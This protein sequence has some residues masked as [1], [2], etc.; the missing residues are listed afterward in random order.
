MNMKII[1]IF[2]I[3][4]TLIVGGTSCSHFD[5]L[6]SNPD[7]AIQAPAAMMATTLILDVAKQGGAKYFIYDNLISKQIAWGEGADSYQYNDFGRTDFEGYTVL[8]VSSKMIEA[9]GEDDKN[10][11]TA[12]AK[13]IKAYKIF[14]ISM[15]VGDVP[16]SDAL[17]GEEGV[18]NPKYDTQKD[19]MVQVLADLDESYRLFGIGRDFDG[20]P[21]YGGDVELWKKCVRAFQLKVL[22]HLSKKESDAELS[23]KARFAQIVNEGSLFTSNAENFQ[24]VYSDKSGQLY[25]FCKLASNHVGLLI[26]SSVIIDNLKASNDYRLFYYASPAKSQIESGITSENWDAYLSVDPSETYIVNGRLFTENK[27]CGINDR[28]AGRSEGEPLIRL[29]FGEQNF[30]LAEAVIRGW[31]S[32][33]AADYYKKGIKASMDFIVK[34]TPNDQ[35]YHNGK[36]MTDDYITNYYTSQANIQLGAD[37]EGNLEKIILQRYLSSFMQHPYD[38]YYDYRRTGYPV[39]PISAATNLN[40]VKDKIPVRWMYPEDEFGF[41]AENANE[42]VQRQYE[43]SDEVNKLMWVLK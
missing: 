39:L 26:I 10:S 18:Q 20:D 22:L 1:N 5:D 7:S 17:K 40:P 29:G 9:A 21:I 2:I 34:Y 24:L 36:P 11:Y 27:F 16:Y 35:M 3:V 23:V 31:I 33:D 19:V 6:N 13:F 15:Q 28:Y 37:F 14:Y 8:S 43:G 42:A 12:L 32:G 30:I 38:A 4:L 25:P 41:N